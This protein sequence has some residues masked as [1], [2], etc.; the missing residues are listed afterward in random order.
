MVDNIVI[1]FLVQ[2]CRGR[3][4][5][6]GLENFDP[7]VMFTPHRE[8]ADALVAPD[9]EDAKRT[10]DMEDAQRAPDVKDAS[11]GPKHLDK[12][13]AKQSTAKQTEE[14]KEARLKQIEMVGN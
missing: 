12:A 11:G 1:D 8:T 10:R 6:D 2:A 14:D 5:I 3:S 7:G 13:D 9:M 4:G